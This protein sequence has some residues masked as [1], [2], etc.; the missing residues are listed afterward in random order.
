[1]PALEA[2]VEGAFAACLGLALVAMVALLLWIT[3]PYPDSGPGGALRVAASLWLL[4]HGAELV[5]LDTLSGVPA[6]VGVTPLLL[7]AL[8]VGLL[9]RAVRAI[10]ADGGGW[11]GVGCLGGGYLVVAAGVVGYSVTGPLAVDPWSAALHLPLLTFGTLT[12]GGW[13]AAGR[14]ALRLPDAFTRRVPGWPSAARWVRRLRPGAAVRASG[15]AVA[16]LCGGGALLATVGLAWHGGAVRE[17]FPQLTSAWSG[18][19]AVLLLC[20]ALV[21]NV[22]VWGAAF[23]LGPG[24]TLGA[25]SAVGPLATTPYPS[26]PHFPLL[27]A[28]PGEGGG[29]PV[30]WA[31]AGAVP[32]AAGWAAGWSAARAGVPVPGT[33]H[34]ATGWRGTVGTALLGA[35]GCGLAMALLGAAAS[36]PLGTAALAHLG[37][38]WWQTGGAAVGWTAVVSVPVALA[39]RLWRVK[40]PHPLLAVALA[41]R[42]FATWCG[43]L[44]G[45]ADGEPVGDWH[46]TGARL[47]R[48]AA[49]KEA[50]GGLMAD[51]EP[52]WED[53]GPVERRRGRHR[54]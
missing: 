22:A 54:R 12:V 52:R 19:L 39:V 3:S 40:D 1:M 8:P 31:A 47:A 14:E 38:V 48:W 27:A 11:R 46:A 18:Q 41:W 36:G 6:P 5:R 42:R 30:L 53:P 29:Y 9:Y 33:R 15:A 26:L 23:G 7:T 45:R 32:V 24:F 20:V 2:V 21:P 50:S 4:A 44:R 34:G 25:G 16:V 28:V 49:L 43:S 37:P 13:C 35:L 10:R 17:A 51:F